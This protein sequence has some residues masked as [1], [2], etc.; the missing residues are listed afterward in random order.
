[1]SDV[2]D[3]IERLRA[4]ESSPTSYANEPTTCWHRNPDG[5]EAADLIERYLATIKQTDAVEAE[6]VAWLPHDGEG[7]P[8]AKETPVEIITRSGVQSYWPKA[9]SVVWRYGTFIAE[10]GDGLPKD[11]EVV[12]YRKAIRGAK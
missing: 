1:M 7:C 12:F 5:P 4:V 8:V 10:T 6:P 11:A 2:T 9:R 3:L